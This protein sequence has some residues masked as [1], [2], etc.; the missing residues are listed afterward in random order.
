M[1]NLFYRR[2]VFL[3][4]FISLTTLCAVS[5]PDYASA[6]GTIQLQYLQD[7]SD[8]TDVFVDLSADMGK[9]TSVFAGIG[10]TQSDIYCMVF[11]RHCSG[12]QKK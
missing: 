10:N 8:T 3:F 12:L 5:I 11:I 6:G 1:S 4:A 7:S 9:N 2:P